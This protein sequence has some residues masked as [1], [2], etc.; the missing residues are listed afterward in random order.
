MELIHPHHA[1]MAGVLLV[2]GL[3]VLIL[4]SAVVGLMLSLF[5]V[6]LAVHTIRSLWTLTRKAPATLPP[7]G[8]EPT[9]AATTNEVTPA[10]STA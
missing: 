1:V 5:V 2:H 3:G 4:A 10:R 9:T 6:V 7:V 8:P